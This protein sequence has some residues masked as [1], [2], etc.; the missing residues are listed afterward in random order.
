MNS[1][2]GSSTTQQSQLS[3]SSNEQQEH[4]GVGGG[5]SLKRVTYNFSGAYPWMRGACMRAL[6]RSQG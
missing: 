4:V 3:K 2:V 5:C 1:T 6:S